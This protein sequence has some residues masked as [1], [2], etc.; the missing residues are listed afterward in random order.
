MTTHLAY[1]LFVSLVVSGCAPP[2]GPSHGDGLKD[3]TLQGIGDAGRFNSLTS[4][5]KVPC[6]V[7]PG[8]GCC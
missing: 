6:S 2:A 1:A 7:S 8:P 3:G 5:C 4:G